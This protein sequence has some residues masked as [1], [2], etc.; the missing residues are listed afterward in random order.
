MS[1]QN[2]GIV[3]DDNMVRDHGI[4]A[5]MIARELYG[6]SPHHHSS[7]DV[8]DFVSIDNV[9]SMTYVVLLSVASLVQ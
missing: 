3:A 4:E 1:R 6:W 9:V 7:S 2:P 5:V 8:I